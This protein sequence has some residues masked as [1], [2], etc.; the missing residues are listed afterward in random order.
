MFRLEFGCTTA[1]KIAEFG[2]IPSNYWH[3][4]PTLVDTIYKKTVA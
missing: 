2:H 3:H 1:M 4:D